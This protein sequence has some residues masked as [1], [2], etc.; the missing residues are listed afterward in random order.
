MKLNCKLP[1]PCEPKNQEPTK[2]P[3]TP[4]DLCIGDYSLHWDGTH[5]SITRLRT[6]PNG[7]YGTI[8]IEN[9]CPISYGEVEVPI[10]TPPYCN[11]NPVPCS[12]QPSSR[13]DV[14]STVTISEREGN[15]LT[16][17]SFGLYAK[18]HLKAVG[19][20]QVLGTGVA[21]DP[22]IIS[23]AADTGG[24]RDSAIRGELPVT[25]TNRNNVSYIGLEQL[26]G[27]SGTYGPFTI[28]N[29]GRVV[30]AKEAN[31]LTTTNVHTEGE[32]TVESVADSVNFS[33]PPSP[34]GGAAYNIGGY[35]I[36]VS[37]VGRVIA[38]ERI[39]T[40]PKGVYKFGDYYVQINEFGSITAVEQTETAAKNQNARPPLAIRDMYKLSY[41]GKNIDVETYGY[42]LT[43][44][45]GVTQGPFEFQYILPDYVLDS[46]NLNITAPIGVNAALNLTERKIAITFSSSLP[47]IVTVV[48]R[49]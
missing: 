33:I 6:T 25:Y 29:Y 4:F 48:F 27:V 7:T 8:T 19:G 1:K 30:A 38:A 32:L 35:A 36:G 11:A 43:P 23:L 2:Q 40:V 44:A 12:K 26:N 49:G 28:D 34:V 22:Y 9:G 21:A 15:Q 20:I 14:V 16:Q 31:F 46:D 39:I 42:P 18:A 13:S 5:A 10:Y 37:P 3:T 47:S 45:V 24:V 17:D 41:D